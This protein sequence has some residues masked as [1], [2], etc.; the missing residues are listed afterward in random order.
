[1]YAFPGES[2]NP[3]TYVCTDMY[4]IYVTLVMVNCVDFYCVEGDGRT[5]ISFAGPFTAV[6][7][8]LWHVVFTLILELLCKHSYHT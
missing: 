1:M 8:S 4:C 7:S 6:Y 5:D 3:G 2:Q